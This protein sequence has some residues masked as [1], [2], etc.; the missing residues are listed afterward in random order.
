MSTEIF[1][2]ATTLGQLLRVKNA[3]VTVAESCTGGGL[4]AAITAVPGSSEWFD[5]GFITYSNKAKQRWLMVDARLLE[6]YGAV[7][8][9]VV[10][11]MAQ[12]ALTQAE[13]DYAIAISGIA[14]PDGGSPDKPVGTVW[15]GW[16]SGLG[17][18][19]SKLLSLKG[20]RESVRQQAV[21]HAL[22]GLLV[23]VQSE[24]D[25]DAGPE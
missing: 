18:H 16:A 3:K 1:H 22:Q 10:E 8:S 9:E 4:G 13:A 20:D 14:G 11:A 23:V 12:G 24:L 19:S 7:S 21:A 15:L 25:H 5:S 2:L 17:H 6:Q